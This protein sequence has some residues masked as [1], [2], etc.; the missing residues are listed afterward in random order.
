[1][2]RNNLTKR[3]SDD[4][5]T[6]TIAII[7]ATG[8]VVTNIDRINAKLRSLLR[9]YAR[10]GSAAILSALKA[11]HVPIAMTPTAEIITGLITT[12]FAELRD[13]QSGWVVVDPA[14]WWK[15]LPFKESKNCGVLTRRV[16]DQAKNGW[17]MEVCVS[18]WSLEALLEEF[19]EIAQRF[20]ASSLSRTIS[21][22]LTS[23]LALLPTP[24]AHTAESCYTLERLC[25]M[26]GF[27]YLSRSS[28]GIAS[29]I[30]PDF[31]LSV[32][33]IDSSSASYTRY[34]CLMSVVG[35]G[36]WFNLETRDCVVGSVYPKSA[37]VLDR[38]K[39]L[40]EDPSALH[41]VDAEFCVIFEAD[42]WD[43]EVPEIPPTTAYQRRTF[44]S[45]QETVTEIV[46]YLA[47]GKNVKLVY[48]SS[49]P[50]ANETEH[51]FKSR[52]TREAVSN[53]WTHGWYRKEDEDTL[54]CFVCI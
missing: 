33:L 5:Q 24:S 47:T 16:T 37:I 52:L 2:D 28:C 34:H 51:Q 44:S 14:I 17:K 31:I 38:A 54:K 10:S 50:K 8:C 3:K 48:A 49:M 25:T 19:E 46:K 20:S 32:F 40:F 42:L 35:D 1:M 45:P 39:I 15:L 18:S 7:K 22:D 29:V 4:G 41:R 12:D 9:Q 43:R 21:P 11:S 36:I 53:G 23:Q 27:K 30:C 26:T 13:A 6:P